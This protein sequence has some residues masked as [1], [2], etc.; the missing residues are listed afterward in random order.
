MATVDLVASTVM[1]ASA[2]LLN[3]TAKTVY[4]YA[5]QIPYLRIAMNELQEKYQLNGISAAEQTSAV[6]QVNAGQTT[7]TF[8]AVVT[9]ALPDDLIEPLKLWERNRGIDPFIP[10]THVE[11][12][13]RYME[14]APTSQ[15]VW[16][17]WL[18]QQITFL[19]STANNDVKIDYIKTLFPQLVDE[20]SIIN[21]INAR[22]FLEYR[23]AGLCAEF[24]ERN[25]SS[26][27]GLNT[28][29]VLALD[30]ALGIGVKGKQ[31]IQT[32]RR[33]FRQ[34]YKRRIGNW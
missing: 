22:S 7:I 11:F 15:L 32:R 13:P 1:D 27:Q 28:Y 16:W 25:M 23:T 2:S 30:R 26:A 14:G 10:M 5:A 12:L 29:A 4:T 8:N 17:T 33:P 18:N 24:I 31:S 9:P 34:A 21:V 20:N 19:P 6:I 3:D